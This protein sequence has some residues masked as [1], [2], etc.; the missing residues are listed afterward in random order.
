ML[1]NQSATWLA[2]W[3]I[4]RKCKWP[5]LAFEWLS[6]TIFSSILGGLTFS[7]LLSSDYIFICLTFI[8][9][10]LSIV[11]NFLV[12]YF[13]CSLQCYHITSS[14]ISS[15]LKLRLLNMKQDSDGNKVVE[16]VIFGPGKKKYRYCKVSIAINFSLTIEWT[17]RISFCYV[18]KFYSW[19]LF[20]S[21]TIKKK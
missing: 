6:H 16:N 5:Y 4:W 21:W 18:V 9:H 19:S 8:F 1:A 3:A 17:F 12:S 10:S 2:S 14:C 7:V 13:N 11:Y 15:I 20:L